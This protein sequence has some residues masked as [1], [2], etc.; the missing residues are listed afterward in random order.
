MEDAKIVR[1]YW[2]RDERA[3]PATSEKYGRYCS[4]I[5]MQILG[6]SEDAEECVNDTYLHAWNSMPPHKPEML[7]AFL[8]K[9]TRNLS[10]NRYKYN[11]AEKR[12]GGE[13]PAIL[14]ELS[15]LV[16]DTGD[17]ADALYEKELVAAIN[18]FLGTLSQ[19]KRC[20]FVCRYWYSDSVTDIAARYGMRVG[21]V[22]MTLNRM[23]KT[24]HDYLTER[25]YT[26]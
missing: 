25:G 21:A 10:F 14:E 11:T 13:V 20:I 2:E 1:L 24:L 17:T 23:R 7:S 4:A 3:I 9:L 26:L 22:S 18:A 16:S 12:G 8:G 19:K 15:E 5:A 6:N